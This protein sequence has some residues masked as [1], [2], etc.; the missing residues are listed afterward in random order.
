MAKRV[1]PLEFVDYG[2]GEGDAAWAAVFGLLEESEVIVKINISPFEIEDFALTGACSK[3]DEDDAI[4]VG[5]AA[6]AAGI[7]QAFNFGF[8]KDAVAPGIL[9]KLLQMDARAF[10]DPA[11]LGS[12]GEERGERGS[13]AVDC[14]VSPLFS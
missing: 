5:A 7:K 3:R 9:F 2:I 1:E 12:V 13:V 10:V 6:L 8:R 4:E 11:K 14:G